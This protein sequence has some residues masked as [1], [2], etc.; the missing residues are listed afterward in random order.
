MGVVGGAEKEVGGAEEEAGGG[1]GGVYTGFK[2]DQKTNTG[3]H[4]LRK[5]EKSQRGIRGHLI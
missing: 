1:C 4:S 2:I 3:K 5:A